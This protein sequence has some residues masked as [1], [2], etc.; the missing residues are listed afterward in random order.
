MQMIN[1]DSQMFRRLR[2]AF[3]PPS[4]G[5]LISR[6]QV[7]ALA[8]FALSI[9]L[10][11]VLA[12][13]LL[14]GLINNGSD[15]GKYLLRA[16]NL[17]DH[18]ALVYLDQGV[19][20]PD[21]GRMPVYPYFLAGILE[22]FG[23]EALW[24]ISI[25]QA[26]VDVSTVFAIGL[27]AGAVNPRWT[28]PAASIACVWATLIVYASFVLADT[29]FIALFC[30]G[31][32]ACV[33]AVRTK[34]RRVPLLIAAGIL[35]SL[36][37]LTRPTLMFFPYL[38]WPLL[39]YLLWSAGHETKRR[40]I[41]LSAIP[42]I[43]IVLA[44]V[45]RIA[46]NYANYGAPV[47]TTQSGNQA[48]D[49]VDQ[50]MRVCPQCILEGRE[51]LMHADVKVRLSE[52][53]PNARNSPI[54]LDQIRRKVALEYLK[55][56][57]L[58]ALIRGT[59]I[60]VTR[61]VTQSALYETGHQFKLEPAFFSAIRGENFANRLTG[62]AQNVLSDGFLRICAIA[63]AFAI[64]AVLLQLIGIADGLRRREARPYVVFLIA[65]G[66]YFLAVNGPF[67]NPRYAMPLTPVM[68]ILTTVGLMGL[69]ECI[70]RGRGQDDV[71][72]E[73]VTP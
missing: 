48:L 55:D 32:C 50:F 66:A 13:V 35:L 65:V 3:S 70:W 14:D 42:A 37:L 19:L 1:T 73:R 71:A 15:S 30:W 16:G 26:V 52:L 60:A 22:V 47:L 45:P 21:T 28:V 38:L 46:A 12:L 11:Y 41:L 72:E 57:P 23:R 31:L 33:W 2:D 34:H 68:I 6:N 64:G 63:Q 67:G 44:V 20:I 49:V 5:A 7:I 10:A 4:D 54:V 17:L 36:G 59:L 18:G 24:P 62:F 25:I 27:I 56:L 9:R 29:V 8:F 61:S 40:A 39:A 51:E 53:E 58:T 43:M 69:L